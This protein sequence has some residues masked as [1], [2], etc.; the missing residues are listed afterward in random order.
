M[1]KVLI[2]TG[3]FRCCN[4]WI[5]LIKDMGW[6]TYRLCVCMNIGGLD[7][8]WICLIKDMDQF[9]FRLIKDMDQFWIRLIKDTGWV[10]AGTFT[11]TFSQ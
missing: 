5:R 3:I 9:C 8:F 2:K 6:V 10:T 1:E 4:F 7:Q 11:W